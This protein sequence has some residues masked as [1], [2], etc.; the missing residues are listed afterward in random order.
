MSLEGVS[1][2]SGAANTGMSGDI[3]DISFRVALLQIETLDQEIG[4]RLTDMERINDLREAYHERIAAW[5]EELDHMPEDGVAHVDVRMLDP[6]GPDDPPGFG[7]EVTGDTPF[8]KEEIERQIETLQDAVD[9]L[10]ADAEMGML[11]LNRLLSR[12]TQVLQLTSNV[13]SS[14]HQ[15]AMALINNLKV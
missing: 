13:M 1:G 11:G 4:L 8:R 5:R 6:I 3:V 14:E 12:R 2:A 7:P 10:G 9:N 15:T